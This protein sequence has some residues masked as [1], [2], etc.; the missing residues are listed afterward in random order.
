MK[1][2]SF[3]YLVRLQ[4]LGFRFN[5][6]QVQP[7]LRTIVG[8]LNKTFSFIYP[9]RTFKILGAGRTD[10]K[11]SSL[12][13]AFELFLDE[14]LENLDNFLFDF[15]KNLPS[16]IRLLSIEPLDGKF[17]IIK[18]SKTKEYHYFFSF[19]SKNHPF[20]APF[21]T[22]YMEPLNVELM[23]EGASL[24][25]G[26][27]DFSIYTAALKPTTKTVR[28][29]ESC[30]IEVN[31]LLTANFFPE[32]S[33]VLKIKGSGFMR[34]QIRM[35]MGALVQLGKSELTIEEIRASLKPG[36]DLTLKTIAPGS[37]LILNQLYF[38]N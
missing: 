26:T 27:H 12:H 22:N 2:K 35:I 18:D 38:K 33:Y 13:G 32:T 19:G 25:V 28:K 23:K 37:G 16:D 8:M 36:S 11:V 21:I 5:G 31:E 4:Y 34:Y 30:R 14:E 10:A 24:F 20:S 7:K 6:W 17:N 1:K 9:E 3:Y 15:N 29:L